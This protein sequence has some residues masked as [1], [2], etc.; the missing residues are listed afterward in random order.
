MPVVTINPEQYERFDLVTAPPDGFVMLRP[1]P[2]GMKLARRSKAVRTMMRSKPVQSRKEALEQDQVFELATE[3]EWAAAHDFA[4]CIGDH[5][6]ESA[7]GQLIDFQRNTAFA[8]KMLNPR[9]GTEIEQLID[10]LN[11]NEDEESLE[12]FL[13]RQNTLSP[14]GPTEL[15][16][17]GAEHT[18]EKD[19]T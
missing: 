18:M 4:Y 12:D 19:T 1:L 17:A 10:K 6:L 11:N 16:M 14:D 5:N 2:Y 15:S 3:D 8:I 7:P 9:V 13:K